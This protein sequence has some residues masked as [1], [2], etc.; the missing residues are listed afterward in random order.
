MSQATVEVVPNLLTFLREEERHG[1]RQAREAVFLTFNAHLGFLESRALGLCQAAGARVTVVADAGVWDPDPRGTL[2]AGYGYHVGLVPNAGAFHPKVLVLVG[3]ARALVAVGS[4]NLTLGGWQ[5]NAELATV[6]T[7]DRKT[8]PAIFR[9]V[10]S[11]LTDLAQQATLDDLTV[12]ALGRTATDL[13]DLMSQATLTDPEHR[14]VSSV[15]EPILQQLP[16]GPVDELLMYAPFHDPRCAAMQALIDHFQPER[17]ALMV[18]P[19]WTVINGSSL[20][21]LI[22]RNPVPIQV[23]LDPENEE[24][25]GRYRHGKLVE[26]VAGGQRWALTG[27]ANLST[28]A[29]RLSCA[30]PG[31]NY[32]VGVV[33]PISDTLFPDAI[34][35]QPSQV[36][37]VVI[38]LDS[39]A[40][41]PGAAKP[42]LLSAILGPDCV[43]LTLVPWPES[44]DVQVSER[45]QSPDDWVTVDVLAADTSE[46]MVKPRV[47]AGSRIRLMGSDHRASTPVFATDPDAVMRRPGAES[48]SRTGTARPHDL[49][50]SDLNVLNA[51]ANELGELARDI[52]ATRGPGTS[53]TGA[54]SGEAEQDG[55]HARRRD[56]D[57][58]QW[59]W[60]K[61]DTIARFGPH[62]TAFSLALPAIPVSG[63]GELRW[64]DR[65]TDDNEPAL[66]D[67]TAE[68][69]ADEEDETEDSDEESETPD[70]S[71]DAE[72]H[73]RA[74][75]RW[76]TKAADLLSDLP[77]PSRMLVL[78]LTLIFWSSGNWKP[79]DVEPVRLV[80]SAARSLDA[81]VTSAEL[82]SRVSSL[83]AVAMAMVRDRVSLD[84]RTEGNL[85]YRGLSRDLAF[86]TMDSEPDLLA[87]YVRFQRTATGA[88]LSVEQVQETVHRLLTEDPLADAMATLEGQGWTVERTRP[89][90]LRITGGFSNPETTALHVLALAEETDP[91]GVWA[92]SDSGKWA[93]MAWSRPD[94][95]RV[96]PHPQGLRWRHQYLTGL[97]GPAALYAQRFSSDGLPYEK[98]HIPQNQ[99]FPGALA[100]LERLGISAAD[101]Q[102]GI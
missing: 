49:W 50:S 98:R 11:L 94:I 101:L 20:Q 64:L 46:A 59:L 9:Q 87:E 72:D 52:A 66:E 30:S 71:H 74:R 7:G 16:D 25:A 21:A 10:A 6:F 4:G 91:V 60:V 39:A 90:I 18:Q 77:L 38:T 95:I 96:T 23:L 86:L 73:K 8:S 84:E 12:R 99:P 45:G 89:A 75:R 32:E 51:L 47:L 97:V 70:H 56:T 3:P 44:L 80:D 33:S 48:R 92:V 40:D 93:F 83:A 15:H 43:G 37:T 28:A 82:E 36:P 13:N 24:S 53:D 14:L 62:L 65:L 55:D 78:R 58:Q 81:T 54:D 76:C 35:L 42:I 22:D 26:W 85:I 61:D 31:G 68:L 29:L 2:H 79:G 34:P 69:V 63:Q 5:Y 17:V 100:L 88:P 27:S 67:D 102:R 57:V 19:G 1:D 41:D